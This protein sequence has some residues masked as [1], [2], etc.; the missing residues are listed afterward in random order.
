MGEN[1]PYLS[2]G[3]SALNELYFWARS[4]GFLIQQTV[5]CIIWILIY[6][7]LFINSQH[8]IFIL[9]E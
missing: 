9:N 1:I 3:L 2:L 4:D 8:E 7:L 5:L 6:Y